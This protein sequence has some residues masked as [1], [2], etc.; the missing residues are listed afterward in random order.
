M[1]T[2]GHGK[3][4]GRE[5]DRER[6]KWKEELTLRANTHARR[7]KKGNEARRKW[8]VW[9]RPGIKD[10]HT[11]TWRVHKGDPQLGRAR[12]NA[13]TQREDPTG[14]EPQQRGQ[15]RWGIRIQVSRDKA[16]ERW[17]QTCNHDPKSS[18]HLMD[19]DNVWHHHWKLLDS[20]INL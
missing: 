5:Y 13:H 19:K 7:G 2:L 18:F 10:I 6:Q 3:G 12:G 14:S 4:G 16:G 8:A 9:T 20:Y 15:Q 17:R 11:W 1:L